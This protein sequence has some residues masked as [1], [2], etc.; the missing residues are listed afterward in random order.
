MIRTEISHMKRNF[1]LILAAVMLAA[2]L[3]SCVTAPNAFS[4]HIRITSSDA[5]DTAAWLS[6]RLGDSLTDSVVIGTDAEAYDVDLDAFEDDGYLI[7][8]Y[9]D[10][11]TQS[12]L[13]RASSSPTRRITRAR[14]SSASRSPAVTFRSTRSSPRTTRP[15]SPPRTTFRLSSPAP[16]V[17]SFPSSAPRRARPISRSATST[18]K[19]SATSAIPGTSPNTGFRSASPTSIPS[20]APPSAS[21]GISRRR[22]IGSGSPTAT[23]TCPPP[24][25]SRSTRARA[26][27]TSVSSTT[28]RSTATTPLRP[29]RYPT[30][31]RRIRT[32]FTPATAFCRFALRATSRRTPTLRGCTTSRAGSPRTFTSIRFRT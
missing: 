26:D 5:A 3:A 24:T 10:A 1:A 7:R 4:A 14:V 31:T 16:A 22:S 9:G 13:R 21:S 18:T 15:S 29:T 28:S 32:S 27:A 2:C 12:P 20:P 11:D 19:R 30:R 25:L 23:R 8:A 6:A 17:S